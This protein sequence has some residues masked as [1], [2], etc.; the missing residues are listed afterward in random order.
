MT[1]RNLAVR[2]LAIRRATISALGLLPVSY[3]F[4][5]ASDMQAKVQ[6]FSELSK[7]NSSLI[8]VED[9][10]ARADKNL[11]LVDV[12]N[13]PVFSVISYA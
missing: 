3:L 11:E 4:L 10:C 13:T 2:L 8:K 1:I 6:K 12:T 7:I 9:F 5:C